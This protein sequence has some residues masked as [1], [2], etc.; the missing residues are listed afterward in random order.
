MRIIILSGT[1]FALA[2]LVG[3]NPGPDNFIAGFILAWAFLKSGTLLIP[4]LLHFAGNL[5]VFV[6]GVLMFYWPLFVL[7][8]TV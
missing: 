6:F 5:C 1:V 4:I 7:H 2:H 3:G 8:P